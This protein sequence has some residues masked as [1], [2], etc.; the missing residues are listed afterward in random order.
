M[1]R[2]SDGDGEH[3]LLSPAKRAEA[4][5]ILLISKLVWEH[6][7]PLLSPTVRPCADA[8]CRVSLYGRI[9]MYNPDQISLADLCALSDALFPLLPRIFRE[10]LASRDIRGDGVNCDNAFYCCA[11]V[12][13]LKTAKWIG[14]RHPESLAQPEP[15]PRTHSSRVTAIMGECCYAGHLEFAKWVLRAFDDRIRASPPDGLDRPSILIKA[16]AQSSCSG[17]HFEIMKW[18]VADCDY[19]AI[20]ACWCF[21]P[22]LPDA[23]E[24]L[25]KCFGYRPHAKIMYVMCQRYKSQ[26][27]CHL[28]E[29]V[30]AIPEFGL[31]LI[32]GALD[33]LVREGVLHI[34]RGVDF[35]GND[36]IEYKL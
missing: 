26:Q 11:V 33:R 6:V 5:R 2:A 29:L 19:T 3:I 35:I 15:E 27:R 13:A 31:D 36:V 21:S 32:C 18:L 34:E 9:D 4:D 28:S 14:A 10:F 7:V 30:E 12:G 20:D 22:Q 23:N 24:W 1:K 17:G 16:A 8:M 25:L